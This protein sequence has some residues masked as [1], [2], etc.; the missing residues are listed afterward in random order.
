ML[1]LYLVVFNASFSR[2]VLGYTYGVDNP[3]VSALLTKEPFSVPLI[4]PMLGLKGRY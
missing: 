1:E 3:G 2:E 4:L